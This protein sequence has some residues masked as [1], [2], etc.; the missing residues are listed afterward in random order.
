MESVTPSTYQRKLRA[1]DGFSF[2]GREMLKASG[3]MSTGFSS[4]VQVQW[5]ANTYLLATEQ[6]SS[7]FDHTEEKRVVP[8]LLLC[9]PREKQEITAH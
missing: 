2:P 1:Q 8:T 7:T 3:L 9:R 4:G 6:P 5:A